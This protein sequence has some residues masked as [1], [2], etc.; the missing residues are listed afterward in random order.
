[1]NRQVIIDRI[2]IE[3][4]EITSV[5]D[6][7]FSEMKLIEDI[8]DDQFPTLVVQGGSESTIYDGAV[9]VTD[10]RIVVYGYVLGYRTREADLNAL[11]QYVRD[12]LHEDPYTNDLTSDKTIAEIATDEGW[13]REKGAFRMEVSCRVHDE[14]ISR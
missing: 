9:L 12:K 4:K 8:P 11:I 13:M 3:L 10:F 1:V 2:V 6:N 5:R 14:I 7:V